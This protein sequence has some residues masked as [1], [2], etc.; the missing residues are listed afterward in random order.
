[1]LVA[2]VTVMLSVTALGHVVEVGEVAVHAAPV[3]RSHGS[4]IGRDIS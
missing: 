3:V 1:M 4:K 2:V